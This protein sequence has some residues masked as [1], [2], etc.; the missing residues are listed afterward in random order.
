MYEYQ[1]KG[2]DRAKGHTFIT[3]PAFMYSYG[4]LFDKLYEKLE[5]DMSIESN[6]NFNVYNVVKL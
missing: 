3:V 4:K 6:G 1:D 5:E 2:G